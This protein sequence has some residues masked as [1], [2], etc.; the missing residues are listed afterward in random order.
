MSYPFM[1]DP[2]PPRHGEEEQWL[3][4]E[5]STT[6]TITGR[7]GRH[8]DAL[9]LD[10]TRLD[11]GPSLAVFNHSPDGF[12]WGYGGSGPAQAALGLLLAVGIDEETAVRLHQRFKDDHVATWP[13]GSFEV[14][15][16]I[17]GWVEQQAVAS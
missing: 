1:E 12:A 7:F 17:L 3:P 2:V 8:F 11:P 10:G 15:L 16:D 14:E 13:Q 4:E 6:N 5:E 9:Y